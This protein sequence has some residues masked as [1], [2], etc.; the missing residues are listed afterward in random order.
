MPKW[1]KRHGHSCPCYTKLVL[2]KIIPYIDIHSYYTLQSIFGRYKYFYFDFPWLYKGPFKIT[3]CSRIYTKFIIFY[4]LHKDY[5]HVAG[6]NR[7]EWT[8]SSG[9]PSSSTI[10][11]Y[12]KRGPVCIYSSRIIF[13]IINTVTTGRILK[14]F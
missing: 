6:H 13:S 4:S 8:L 14:N 9:Y 1:F 11:T 12:P 5:Y 3:T 10:D 2:Q 7:S